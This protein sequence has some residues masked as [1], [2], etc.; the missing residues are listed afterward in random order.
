[1]LQNAGTKGL[2]NAVITQISGRQVGLV[3]R[4]PHEAAQD[5][6]I[7]IGSFVAV[8]NLPASSALA[9]RIWRALHQRTAGLFDLRATPWPMPGPELPAPTEHLPPVPNA[10][11]QQDT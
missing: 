4:A 9:Q 2:A 10:P 5:S 3:A 11:W 8:Q 1:M 6:L 7:A